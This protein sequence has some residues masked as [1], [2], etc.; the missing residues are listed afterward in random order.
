MSTPPRA[1]L[2]PN[3]AGDL[4]RLKLREIADTA[5]GDIET[6]GGSLYAARQ[7]QGKDLAKVAQAL[8]I[9]L[10]YLEALEAGRYEELPGTTYAVGFVRSYASYLQ[11]NPEDLVRR[12]KAEVNPPAPEEIEYDFPETKEEIRLPRGIWVI[13]ALLAIGG[14]VAGLYFS[15]AASML[16]SRTERVVDPAPVVSA[17]GSDPDTVAADDTGDDAAPSTAPET[18][19]GTAGG[20]PA[21]EGPIVVARDPETAPITSES[22]DAALEGDAGGDEAG[23]D[24]APATTD[25]SN[26]ETQPET[27]AA[28][29]DTAEGTPEG[30]P[31][32]A[33]PATEESA[34]VA[35]EESGEEAGEETAPPPDPR[36]DPLAELAPGAAVY[37]QA[38]GDARIKLRAVG[39]A[40][41]RV[42]TADGETV[43]EQV[44][45]RGDVFVA[46]NQPGLILTVRNAG[47]FE[48][49]VDDIPRGRL[50]NA[51]VPIPE[52]RLDPRTLRRTVVPGR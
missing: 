10:P 2:D 13:V 6:V 25:P 29:E 5:P 39:P 22:D 18:S 12:F 35:G 26:T 3:R 46:P 34:E 43:I 31:E 14:V 4:S 19:D 44:L 9:R 41:L 49:F 32:G 16:F 50:G 28:S 48:V 17:N 23:A 7:R 1:P 42:D 52:M 51:G 20:D 45:N 47:A 8:R 33:G 11:L 37:G 24:T 40:W 15:D 27:P 30:A 38:A 36:R 21:P